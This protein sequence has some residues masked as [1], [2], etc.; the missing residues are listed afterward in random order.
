[1]VK[2]RPPVRPRCGAS[3]GVVPDAEGKREE[4]TRPEDAL[5]R[6]IPTMILI[7]KR[8]IYVEVTS[9]G[10]GKVQGDCRCYTINNFVRQNVLENG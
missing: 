10:E 7:T 8:R 6:H 4:R 9:L 5:E 2:A 3:P 1:M